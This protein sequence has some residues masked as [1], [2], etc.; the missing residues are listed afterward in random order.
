MVHRCGGYFL[1]DQ[2]GTIG[3]TIEKPRTRAGPL[4]P[5]FLHILQG[6]NP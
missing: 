2:R 4:R 5:G 3:V 1:R 6:G